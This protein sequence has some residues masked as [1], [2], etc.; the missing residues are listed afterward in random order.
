MLG[1]TYLLYDA[2]NTLLYTF[3]PSFATESNRLFMGSPEVSAIPK[4][5]DTTAFQRVGDNLPIPEGYTLKGVLTGSS[6]SDLRTQVT[7]LET[8]INNATK[9]R[10]NT[11]LGNYDLGVTLI[12]LF[13]INMQNTLF[14]RCVYS[15]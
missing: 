15:S 1:V 11:P 9:L 8:A 10:A 12:G 4:F 5:D 13:Q 14:Q 7:T 6:L 3:S 2:T